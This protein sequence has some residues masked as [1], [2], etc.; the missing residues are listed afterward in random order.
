MSYFASEVLPLDSDLEAGSDV[1]SAVFGLHYWKNCLRRTALI[2][3][4]AASGFYGSGL[5]DCY[6]AGNSLSSE[7]GNGFTKLELFLID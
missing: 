4:V 1:F 6:T 3:F 5:G 7:S 2:G